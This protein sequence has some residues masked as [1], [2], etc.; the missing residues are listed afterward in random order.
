MYKATNHNLDSFI[1]P[2]YISDI[3]DKNDTNIVDLLQRKFDSSQK[4]LRFT[5]S[6]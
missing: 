5:I 3:I 1:P 2:I 6:L 4:L